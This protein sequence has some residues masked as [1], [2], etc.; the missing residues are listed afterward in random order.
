MQ[1]WFK[2]KVVQHLNTRR[3]FSLGTQKCRIYVIEFKKIYI[4]QSG[5]TTM[6]VVLNQLHT[7]CE[8]ELHSNIAKVCDLTLSIGEQK[9]DTFNLPTKLQVTLYYADA[10]YNMQQHLQAENLYRQALQIRKNILMK[11]KNSNIKINENHSDIP[12]DVDIKY[13]IHLCCMALKQKNAAGEIL[14]MISA[15]L[16]T[17]KINMALGDIY[18]E[19]G[20]ERSAITCYKEVL[21]ECPLALEAVENLLK[22]GVKGVEV[23]SLMV[24]VSSEISW[25]ST[26]VKAQAQMNSKD[27][28]N[29]IKTFKTMDTHGLLKDN[30][31]LLVNMAYCYHY[32][33]EDNR[34]ISILQKALRLDPFLTVGKD[35][36]STLLAA[37]GTKEHIRALENLV[38][39]TDMS[40]WTSEHWVVLGNYNYAMKKY[41]KAAYFGQ[42]AC[43]MDRKN[44][45]ALLLK[46][47]TLMQ[48][49]KY[50]DAASHCTEALQ[51]C[52]Y[53]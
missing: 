6:N 11:A 4:S 24:E 34:A 36:L 15:R 1:H 35:L 5:S 9:P 51:I 18:K 19:I 7:L 17:P 20:M 12:S 33:C 30:T 2:K 28:G 50:N 38:P 10:L 52:N 39:A 8:K 32:M 21:R 37:S 25:L 29:A 46:A 31:S 44:V 45:E 23:N 47:N 27:F 16:R 13:K 41:D 42:Q 49:K 43:L 14:Q 3:Q 26:W 53:S 22:L 40:L 48:I